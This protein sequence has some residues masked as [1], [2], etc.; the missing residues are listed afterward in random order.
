MLSADWRLRVARRG[1]SRRAV[2]RE[3]AEG[4]WTGTMLGCS[5]PS[6]GRARDACR[7]AGARAEPTGGPAPDSN[8]WPINFSAARRRSRRRYQG[9]AVGVCIAEQKFRIHLSPAESQE[10]TL[11]SRGSNA[12]QGSWV[13]SSSAALVEPANLGLWETPIRGAHV[14]LGWRARPKNPRWH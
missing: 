5:S 2:R 4:R 13:R 12:G 1:T 11:C 8:S 6:P 7:Q 9:G 10:R 3:G 14:V